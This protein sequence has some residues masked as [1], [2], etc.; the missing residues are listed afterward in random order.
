MYEEERLC[1]RLPIGSFEIGWD[2][3]FYPWKK[4]SKYE[5]L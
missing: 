2:R 4:E 5:I 1:T 3:L